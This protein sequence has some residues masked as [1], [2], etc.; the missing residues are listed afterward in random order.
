MRHQQLAGPETSSHEE[1]ERGGGVTV[2]DEGGSEDSEGIPQP[3]SLADLQT[4]ED[5]LTSVTGVTTCTSY[6]TQLATDDSRN[7]RQPLHSTVAVLNPNPS[8]PTV[9]P[10]RGAAAHLRLPSIREISR[11]NEPSIVGA[12]TTDSGV[13]GSMDINPPPSSRG[14]GISTDLDSP[15]ENMAVKSRQQQLAIRS[16]VDS[17]LVPSPDH[18]HTDHTHID[19]V[20]P[21]KRE[22]MG[23]VGFNFN[24]QPTTT[25]GEPTAACTHHKTQGPTPSRYSTTHLHRNKLGVPLLVSQKFPANRLLHGNFLPS[26]PRLLPSRQTPPPMTSSREVTPSRLPDWFGGLLGQDVGHTPIFPEEVVRRKATLKAQLQFC[27]ELC[28]CM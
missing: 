17:G 26:H 12:G 23:A 4:C 7:D 21:T 13:V 11:I 16:E 14:T 28:V 24:P 8:I 18:A 27:S 25:P 19:E 1:G 5:D 9:D 22:E 10:H 2:G 3:I 6:F 15:A 20:A